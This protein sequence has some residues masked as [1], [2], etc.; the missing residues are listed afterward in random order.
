MSPLNRN[1]WQKLWS[2]AEA[3][4]RSGT[5]GT[6]HSA[7]FVL[8]RESQDRQLMD[9]EAKLRE[10]LS[11]LPERRQIELVGFLDSRLA[12]TPSLG[13]D[14]ASEVD[15]P[16]SID[17]A[18]IQ[19]EWT[20]QFDSLRDQHIFQWTA[21]YRRVIQELLQSICSCGADG[22]SLDNLAKTLESETTR[23]ARQIYDKGYYH[24][25]QRL[26][27]SSE[28]AIHKS[29]GGL[30]GFLDALAKSYSNLSAIV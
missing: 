28:E 2:D 30:Q 6:A 22:K 12:A 19:A 1:A 10:L 9:S 5:Y 26:G 7:L 13:V 15:V 16:A 4:V 24:V 23:H 11:R 17:P 8:I 20:R 21:H 27:F 25:T 14:S 18:T 3:L 29:L